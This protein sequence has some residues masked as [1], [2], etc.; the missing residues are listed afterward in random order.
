MF[1]SQRQRAT[2]FTDPLLFS[3][4]ERRPLAVIL[5]ESNNARFKTQRVRHRIQFKTVK[6]NRPRS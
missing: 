1:E 4:E 2:L 5:D 6:V 3:D